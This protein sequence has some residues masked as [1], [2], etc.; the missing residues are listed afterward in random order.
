MRSWLRIFANS[1]IFPST[2]VVILFEFSSI[3]GCLFL[4]AAR[5]SANAVL[6]VGAISAGAVFA[7][8]LFVSK[9][10]A[11]FKHARAFCAKVRD[12]PGVAFT[13]AR[14]FCVKYFKADAQACAKHRQVAQQQYL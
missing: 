2:R 10:R 11:A 9:A 5:S 4:G 6:L 13:L 12:A 8:G 1:S 14:A 3:K 7:E